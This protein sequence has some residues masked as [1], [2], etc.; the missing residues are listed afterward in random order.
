MEPRV[1]YTVVGAFVIFLTAMLIIGVLWF[2]AHQQQQHQ[3]YAVYMNEA[4]SGLSIQ[5][6]VKFSGV[7]VG[8]VKDIRLNHKDP[9]KVLLL[10]AINE[11]TPINQSTTATLMSQGI[12]GVTYVGLKATAEHAPP[13]L[14]QPGKKYPVIRSTPSLLV[15]LDAALR[16]ASTDIHKI[17]DLA[18]QLFSK[19]NLAAIHNTLANIE[20]VTKAFALGSPDIKSTFKDAAATMKASSSAAQTISQQTLPGAAEIFSRMNDVLHSLEQLTNTVKNNPSVLIR[21]KVP[22]QPGPGE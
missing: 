4:V 15:Q 10:L 7:D 21:G 3:I 6:P 11:G 18:E 17:T 2:S 20:T 19:D 1:N 14:I 16:E 12:T 13:L 9:R 8:Y 5:A 22:P